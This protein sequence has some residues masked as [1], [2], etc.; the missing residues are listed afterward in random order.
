[1]LS[2]ILRKDSLAL[3]LLG[4][5]LIL[6]FMGIVRLVSAPEETQQ[7]RIS[8]GPLYVSLD[9]LREA[10]DLVVHGRVDRIVESYS[11][12]AGNPEFDERGDP[13]PKL[14]KLI[15]RLDVELVLVGDPT[16]GEI[17]VITNDTTG[18]IDTYTPTLEPGQEIVLYLFDV[19]AEE[20][21]SELI[22]RDRK[23]GGLYGVVGGKQG[24]F[25]VVD[26]RAISRSDLKELQID[27]DSPSVDD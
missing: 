5:G 19:P 13:L 21:S 16:L 14:P 11:D 26:G 7:L 23:Y 18:I 10:S 1:M 15:M 4:A 2:Q 20:G 6:G 12:P 25:D 27:L 24:V 17:H 9:A 22:A 8:D 3:I